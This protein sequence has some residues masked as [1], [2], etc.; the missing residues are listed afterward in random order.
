MLFLLETLQFILYISVYN[1]SQI[2]NVWCEAEIKIHF[3]P[4]G[5]SSC[6]NK[7]KIL[8]FDLVHVLG[9]K[10]KSTY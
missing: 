5:M 7:K 2:K 6:E 4:L 8:I 9:K 3:I 10:K 1:T